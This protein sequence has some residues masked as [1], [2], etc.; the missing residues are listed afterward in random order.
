MALWLQWSFCA[1]RPW[2]DLN[3]FKRKGQHGEFLEH[4]FWGEVHVDRYMSTGRIVICSELYL[5]S[6]HC[7]AVWQTHAGHGK[8]SAAAQAKLRYSR[9]YAEGWERIFARA[10][11]AFGGTGKP[12]RV[13]PLVT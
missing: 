6:S 11:A 2:F 12:A 1:V 5:S 13:N 4:L 10:W 3:S 8:I 9:K 7:L